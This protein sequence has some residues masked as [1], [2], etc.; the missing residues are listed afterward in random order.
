MYTSHC[1]LSFPA[2]DY[3]Y[4]LESG[5]LEMLLQSGHRTLDPEE[6]GGWA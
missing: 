4:N 3:T 2:D 1:P 5:F 6:A